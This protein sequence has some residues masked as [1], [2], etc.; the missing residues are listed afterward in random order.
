M[1]PC[2]WVCGSSQAAARYRT[3]TGLGYPS[4]AEDQQQALSRW[5][6][7]FG[8]HLIYQCRSAERIEPVIIRGLEAGSVRLWTDRA[9]HVPQKLQGFAAALL[10]IARWRASPPGPEHLEVQALDTL[11][12]LAQSWEDWR[13]EEELPGAP[14][15]S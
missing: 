6:E 4:F 10:P 13:G 9:L 8:P 3:A 2:E 5:Q 7:I 1:T 15:S 14:K 11:D 12:T